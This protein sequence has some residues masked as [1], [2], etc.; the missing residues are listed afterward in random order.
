VIVTW[1]ELGG[2][3]PVVIVQEKT[4]TPGLKA[5]TEVWLLVKF[6]MFPLP[7]TRVHWPFPV[8]GLFPI[9]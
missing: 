7:W 1:S 8:P 5:V 9:N 4:L 3:L 6:V 2:Q